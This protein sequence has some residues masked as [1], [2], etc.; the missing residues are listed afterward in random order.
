MAGYKTDNTGL[1]DSKTVT[2]AKHF[3]ASFAVGSPENCKFTAFIEQED[4]GMVE[5]KPIVDQV[6]G[7]VEEGFKVLQV[8]G[9]P[10]NLSR[11]LKLDGLAF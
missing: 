2:T 4:A 5:I 10:G 9:I 11:G 7:S 8:A 3:L 1:A 6:D